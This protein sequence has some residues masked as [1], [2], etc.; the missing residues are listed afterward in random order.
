MIDWDTPAQLESPYGTLLFNQQS[1]VSYSPQPGS[2]LRGWY[3]LD[4]AG[5]SSERA[6]RPEKDRVPQGDGMIFHRRFT[7]GSEFQIRVELWQAPVG[8]TTLASGVGRPACAE[9]AR[10]M[11]EELLLHLGAIL[12]G[13]GRYRWTP[14][15]HSDNRFLDEARWLVALAADLSDPG[16]SKLTFTIDS[17]FPYV[18]D[19]TQVTRFAADDDAT[20]IDNDGNTPFYPVIQVPGATGSFVIENQ[21]TGFQIEYDEGRPGAQGI[22]SGDFAEIDTF[23]NTIYLNGDEDNLKPGIDPTVSDFFPLEPGSNTIL[24]T[25]ADADFLVNDAYIP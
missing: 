6:L 11:E 1:A 17:P 7:E 13:D 20:E 10:L 12:N 19:A 14:S 21:T 2:D 3:V 25:G 15:G 8:A 22:D 9:L 4:R 18:I 5:C 23:R 24:I 16:M